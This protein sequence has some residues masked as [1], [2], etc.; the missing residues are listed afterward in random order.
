[1]RYLLPMAWLAGMLAGALHPAT[2]RGTVVEHQTGKALTR[3]LVVVTPVRGSPGPTVSVRTNIYG[4]FETPPLPAGAYLVSVSRR[5]FAPAQYGQKRWK[6]PGLPVFLEE[7]G[8]TFLN[9]RLP[10]FG[11]VSGT[12]LDENDVGLP[13]HDVA[14]YRNTHPPQLVTR[15][16]TDDRGMYRVA[17]L[18]P[19]RYLVR[20]V[21]RQYEEGGYLPTFHKE[22]ALVDQAYQVEVEIDRETT[23]VN[24]RPHPGQLFSIAGQAIVPAGGPAQL[25]LVS[26]TGSE[27]TMS[28]GEGGFRF[29]PAAPGR[30][31]LYA[32]APGDRRGPVAAFLPFELERDRTDVRIALRYYPQLAM[33]YQ[34]T[35]GQ[36]V[37]AAAV[38]LTIRRKD[39][40]GEGKPETPHFNNGVAPL[41]P[42][43]WEVALVPNAKYFAEKFA[44]PGVDPFDRGRADGWNEIVLTVPGPPASGAGFRLSASPASL[45]G[46]VT[47][48]GREPAAG[49]PVYLELYDLEARKRLIDVRETHTDVRG[50]Y[51]FYGLAPGNYRVVSTFEFLAPDSATMDSA[52]P[53][54]VQLEEGRDTTLDLDLYVIR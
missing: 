31:E 48:N 12:I 10:R 17:G 42:G 8:S 51:Q 37:D 40:A 13:E 43:R 3:A 30:Y 54:T 28:D 46:I 4:T 32:Q 25:T 27:S 11:S 5:S 49:A 52:S 26:D 24:V 20:T 39:L 2:I 6:A 36:V 50:Q 29:P 16:K 47:Q 44:G 14:I 22:T 23:D 35:R 9:I 53:R 15:V 33:S 21:G 34:D 38:Q 41:L 1:M 18:E 19:G 45:H 7:A